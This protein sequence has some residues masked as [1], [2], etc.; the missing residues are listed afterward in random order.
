[1][2]NKVMLIGRLGK[3]PEIRYSAGG[4]AICNFSMATSEYYQGEEK[5]E[6]HKIV[7]FGKTAERCE[8]YL[9]KG[10]AQVRGKNGDNYVG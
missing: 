7:T 10:G 1:M 8:E 3:D 6:W 4:T 2:L 9:E 5:T